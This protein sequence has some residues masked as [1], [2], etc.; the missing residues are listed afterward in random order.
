MASSTYMTF[1]M[2]K[3]GESWAKMF[4]IKDH[5]DLFGDPEMLES[6]TMSDRSQTF[7]L[8]VE[9]IDTLA[10]TGNYDYTEFQ[11]LKQG[12]NTEGDFAVWMG[13]TENADGTVTPTGENGKFAWKGMYR[14][15]VAGKG[16]NEIRDMV[17]TF[18]LKSP[19]ALVTG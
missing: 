10:F 18:S 8:G 14:M 11:T 15:K 19:M 5:P 1:L 16:V 2:K 17:A 9:Q 4:D 7:A 3:T 12:E 6:T 13:G